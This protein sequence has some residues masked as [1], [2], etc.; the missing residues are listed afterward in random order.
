[1]KTYR[2]E[3]A[4]MYND[5]SLGLWEVSTY[6]GTDEI[7]HDYTAAVNSADQR[8]MRELDGCAWRVEG[9]EHW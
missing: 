8:N 3:K 1:M 2:L 9:D 6:G 4:P 7:W 5:G